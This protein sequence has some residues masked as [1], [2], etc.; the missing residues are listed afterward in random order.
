MLNES[1]Q[2]DPGKLVTKLFSF[3]MNLM[4]SRSK[5]SGPTFKEIGE[6]F[7]GF[8]FAAIPIGAFLPREVMKD[9]HVSPEES[10]KIHQVASLD[11]MSTPQYPQVFRGREL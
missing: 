10:V 11:L 2:K 1:L 8:D 6:H 4:K 3:V 5:Q 7:G 9:Q